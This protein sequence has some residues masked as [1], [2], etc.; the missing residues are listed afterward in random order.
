MIVTKYVG[1][2]GGGGYVL[3]TA[4][5][6]RLG[7]IKVGSGLS[8]ENDGTLSADGGAGGGDYIVTEALSSIT[9]PTE[10]MIAYVPAH[11]ENKGA[12]KVTYTH[13]YQEESEA[14]FEFH[15]T[16]NNIHCDNLITYHVHPSEE[17]AWMRI[18]NWWDGNIQNM[19]KGMDGH[20][21]QG[22]DI[23][24]AIK[25][26]C[27][28]QKAEFIFDS[29]YTFDDNTIPDFDGWTKAVS[30]GETPIALHTYIYLEN[31]WRLKDIRFFDASQAEIFNM[32]CW[33]YEHEEYI[34]LFSIWFGSAFLTASHFENDW[35]GNTILQ[36]TYALNDKRRFQIFY[37]PELRVFSTNIEDLSPEVPAFRSASIKVLIDSA[38]TET[39]N[40]DWVGSPDS[41]KAF[42]GDI[43]WGGSS[44]Y[45]ARPGLLAGDSEQNLTVSY[46]DMIPYRTSTDIS[47]GHEEFTMKGKFYNHVTGKWRILTQT[48]SYNGDGLQWDTPTIVDE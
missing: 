43:Y 38:G 45:Y 20:T 34:H 8:I 47:A 36:A 1:E 35:D 42:L 22:Y 30:T 32:F 13:D 41:Y 27:D 25:G 14:G 2:G 31:G 46:D 24:G 9:N 6:S 15:G 16:F 10:G 44:T 11:F 37:H 23:M 29:G 3:P 40:Y 18:N 17:W 39:V 7:G 28:Y 5:A 12:T 4:T 21:W 26:K 33:L 48:T 19:L